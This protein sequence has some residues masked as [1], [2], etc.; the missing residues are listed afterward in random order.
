MRSPTQSLASQLEELAALHE[1]LR[2][3]TSTLDLGEVLRILLARIRALTASQ[4]LSLLLYDPRRNDLVFAA[5]ETLREQAVVTPGLIDG[6]RLPVG[7]GIAGWVARHREAVRLGDAA[8][9]PRH[10][11]TLA[12]ETGLVPHG[13][14]CVPLV[15]RG[16]LLGVVQV[17]N[18][19]DGRPFTAEQQRLVQA[20]ADY[21]AVGIA[22][23][24]LYHQVEQASFTDDLTGLGNTRRFH[25]MLPVLLERAL[26]L[27]LVLLDLDR[28]KPL[29]DE[30]G[31]L[32]GSR[33]I[34]TVGRVIAD[35]LRPGD[36]GARFGGDEFVVLLPGT[37]TA[38][39]LVVAERI[40][41]GVETCGR[42]DGLDVD[43]RH[44]TASVGVATAP[45][46]ATDADGLF[47]AADTAM[48]RVKRGARNGVAIAE[49]PAG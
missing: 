13:M 22:N 32:V 34:A 20:L 21:A 29:V 47:R 39:A 27:S 19:L 37:D 46:H 4:A 17:I 43:I 18:R 15:H 41:A 14:I 48:Y 10:D 28:L 2:A 23:A 5:T 1:S 3:L 30:F 40:R 8:A 6:V 11:P 24:Q 33:T 35:L 7:R 45:V 9:D 26:P 36:V 25:H 12:R 38:A 16:R 44:V 31:H 42:P 49:P